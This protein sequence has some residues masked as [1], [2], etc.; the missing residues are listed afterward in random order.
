MIVRLLIVGAR[1]KLTESSEVVTPVP[2]GALVSTDAP[3]A[4]SATNAVVPARKTP[5]PDCHHGLAGIQ[6]VAIPS[7]TSDSRR[8]VSL[9]IGGSGSFRSRFAR[10]TSS[11]DMRTTSP[12]Q[13]SPC[14]DS[15]TMNGSTLEHYAESIR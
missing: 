2:A 7:P 10:K 12:L 6:A 11:P 1:R 13:V 14:G 4:V 8:P 3:R 15:L 9:V 5:A